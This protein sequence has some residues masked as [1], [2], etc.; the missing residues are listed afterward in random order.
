VVGPVSLGHRLLER[1]GAKRASVAVARKLAVILHRMLRDGSTF[2][3]SA[4]HKQAA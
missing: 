1:I 2:R 3:W 4:P